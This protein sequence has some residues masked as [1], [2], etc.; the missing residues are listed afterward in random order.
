MEITGYTAMTAAEFQS[1]THL[2]AR[3]AWM[4]CHF[5]CYSTGLTNLPQTLPQNSMVIVNDRT[6]VHG[7][8][9]EVIARQLCELYE[10][11]KPACFLLDLQRIENQETR[12]IVKTLINALPCPVGV[13]LPYAEGLNC[14]V[15]LPPP[16]I[17]CPLKAHLEPWS[18]REIWLEVAVDAQT[19][20]VTEAG[21]I[22]APV[23]PVPLE[24]PFAFDKEVYCHYRIDQKPDA[25][26]I[27]LLRGKDA[28]QTMLPEAFHLGITTAV[29]LYQQLGADFFQ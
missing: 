17:D 8:D 9:P 26:V 22:F 4:A 1:A 27:S 13:S 5:S 11:Q 18:Q 10:Q 3:F 15:F 19:A 28:L 23:S 14:P 24:E 6:P 12:E 7:H 25:V 16:A 29:G 21:C 2:P 20:T